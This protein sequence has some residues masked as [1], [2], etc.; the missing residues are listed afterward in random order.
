MH[1][2]AQTL[3][4]GRKCLRLHNVRF[5]L[6]G[7]TMKTVRKRHATRASDPASGESVSTEPCQ[8]ER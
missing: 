8:G 1:F 5:P 7:A 4:P 6:R 2:D 3:S